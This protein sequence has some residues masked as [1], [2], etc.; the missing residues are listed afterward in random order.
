MDFKAFAANLEA[1]VRTCIQHKFFDFKGRAARSEYWYFVLF[2]TLINIVISLIA[3]MISE[4]IGS[5]L[6]ILVCLGLLLPSLGV[7]V[8]RLHDLNK[9]GWWLLLGLIPLIGAIILL[10]FFVQRGTVG[11]NNYG[12]DPLGGYM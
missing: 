2:Y 4:T 8:R 12:P 11:P 1:A 6:S 10:V 3:G 7:A 5:V 9:S